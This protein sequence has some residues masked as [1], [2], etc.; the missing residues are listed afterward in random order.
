[1]KLW[2]ELIKEVEDFF[3]KVKEDA[4]Q[5][6]ISEC[7]LVVDVKKFTEAHLSIVKNQNG[8]AR[9]VPYMKRLLTL[10][11]VMSNSPEKT[12]KIPVATEKQIAESKRMNLAAQKSEPLT[13][14]PKKKEPALPPK[15]LSKTQGV[16]LPIKPVKKSSGAKGKNNQSAMGI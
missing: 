14:E 2:N 5:V 1:M 4:S 15:P 9:F 10:K 11:Q 3:A 12:F 16:K 13:K 6:R 8:N 7:E